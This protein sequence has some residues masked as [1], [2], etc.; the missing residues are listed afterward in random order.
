M[1]P[2]KRLKTGDR[3]DFAK[4][5][6]AEVAERGAD[7]EV[8]L[9]FDRDGENL[10][11]ALAKY[12]AMPIPP[13]IGRAADA[14][15]R[16]D[17]QTLFAS[18]DGAVAAPTAGLHFTPEL[19]AAIKARGVAMAGVTLHVG[20]GTFL[21]V[22]TENVLD[23]RMHSEWGCVS[24]ESA[25]AINAAKAKGGRVVAIGTTALRLLESAA[26]ESGV[27]GFSGETDIF[28]TPGF[29]FRAVDLLLTN[30][31]LP[32]STLFILVC[33]FAGTARMHAA[34]AHA[35]DE[36]YRF[37]SYGDCC[38]IHRGARGARRPALSEFGF[39][40]S[41][42]AGSAR[43][44]TLTTAHGTVE[45]PAFMPVGTNATV[46][47]MTPDALR[48]TG[49]EMILANAYH[50]MLRPGAERVADLGGLHRF[51]NWPGPILTD[52]GGFQVMS[53][54]KLRDIDN[55]GV[56]FRSH[57]DGSEHRLTPEA[58]GADSASSRR[59]RHH[60]LRRMHALSGQYRAN[61]NIDAAFH[62]LGGALQSR[63]HGAARLRL[64]RNRPRRRIP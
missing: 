17:Y 47:A 14:R 50:L 57:I 61:R 55:D 36:S 8:L 24:D 23:H 39:Q 29:E 19:I 21:P 26:G 54:A 1:R 48:E 30:F 6:T 10:R 9:R 20:A 51:M 44:G 52:S 18:R 42:T 45:T 7:G 25:R 11:A 60:G 53:L 3:I 43:R 38:L 59:R 63:V 64:I 5:F 28:I 34:Y 2:A 41:A 4:E 46:K 32:R 33:A 49:A 15:D 16:Q 56:T 13:Y 27:H 22:K 12:G 37:F 31:H 35:I 58:R 40:I 62:A